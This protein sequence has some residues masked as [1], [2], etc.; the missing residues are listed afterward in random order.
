MNRH[1]RR[2]LKKARA[3]N[4][5]WNH[6]EYLTKPAYQ[7][8]KRKLEGFDNQLSEAHER[9]LMGIVGRLKRRIV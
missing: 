8:L 4:P 7:R 5:I 6:Y 3:S 2:A 9:A 1:Q